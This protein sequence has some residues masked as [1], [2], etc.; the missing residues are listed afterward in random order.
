MPVTRIK[1]E[2]QIMFSP[3]LSARAK[4]PVPRAD[5]AT[6]IGFTW[7]N[8]LFDASAGS[9]SSIIHRQAGAMLDGALDPF[10]TQCTCIAGTR[11]DAS[12]AE[13]T[14][15]QIDE[16]MAVPDRQDEGE[17]SAPCAASRY[18]LIV[19]ARY[20]DATEATDPALGRE[21]A[22]R[23][24]VLQLGLPRLSVSLDELP[25]QGAQDRPGWHPAY[26]GVCC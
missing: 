11:G 2:P 22:G 14:G 12:I 15:H 7:Q 19:Q 18:R 10:L 25:H 1:A 23:Q 16:A 24:D 4:S 9:S 3:Q 21:S 17:V 8:E 5:S 26:R 6:P 13:A 20:L